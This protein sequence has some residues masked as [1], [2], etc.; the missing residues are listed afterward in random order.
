MKS[1]GDTPTVVVGVSGT[2]ASAEALRWAAD[3]ADRRRDT[4][5]VVRSWS[6]E[7]RAFYAHPAG[8]P[9][10]AALQHRRASE[11]LTATLRAV[12]GSQ[13]RDNVSCE[14]IEGMAERVLV[15]QSAGADLL[16]LGSASGLM[17]GRPIGPVIRGC[18]TRA[19][20]PVVV[21]GPEGPPSGDHDYLD[22]MVRHLGATCYD[23]R[24]HLC[25]QQQA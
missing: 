19:H 12:L 17:A 2:A 8:G 25:S 4:L 6:A 9:Q 24:S 1:R 11:G 5:K 14:V 15:D 23:S 18:L 3:E 10:A 16:V 21:V 22:A 20:C 13:R 7:P